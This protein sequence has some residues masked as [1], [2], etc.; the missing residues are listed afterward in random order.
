MELIMAGVAL[1]PG[2]AKAI[3]HVL[4][5]IEPTPATPPGVP[6]PYP[7]VAHFEAPPGVAVLHALI[8]PADIDVLGTSPSTEPFV[9]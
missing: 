3:S 2:V 6:I 4:S 8:E 7:N 9:L 5:L 1:P